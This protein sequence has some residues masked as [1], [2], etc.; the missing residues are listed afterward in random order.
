MNTQADKDEEWLYDKLDRRKVRPTIEQVDMFCDMVW[1]LI[2][3][4]RMAEKEARSL[5]LIE[6][7]GG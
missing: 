5:A 6:V 7:F 2:V 3:T 4:R 1:E